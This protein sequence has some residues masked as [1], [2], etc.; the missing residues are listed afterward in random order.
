MVRICW[1]GGGENSV[2]MCVSI[3]KYVLGGEVKPANKGEEGGKSY[4]GTTVFGTNN[5]SL[6]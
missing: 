2:V 6:N 4:A 3:N 5:S 1:G